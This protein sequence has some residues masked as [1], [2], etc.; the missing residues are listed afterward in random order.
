MATQIAY[1]KDFYKHDNAGHPENAQRLTVM[2][3][4]LQNTSFYDELDFFE[5]DLINEN[6]LYS[7][8]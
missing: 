5:P 1:S 7:L 2:M 8:H 6:A 3:N 4:E